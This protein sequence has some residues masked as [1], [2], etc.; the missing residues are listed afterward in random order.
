[1]LGVP[2]RRVILNILA[3]GVLIV[4]TG[5]VFGVLLAVVSQDGFN[6]FFQWRYDTPLVFVR[7]TPPVIWRAVRA[8][9]GVAAVGALLFDMLLLSRGLV[10]SLADRLD[11]VG[12][13]VRVTTG[14]ALSIA[15]DRI[16]LA[17]D[18][19][20]TVSRLPEVEAVA[21]KR[22]SAGWVLWSGFRVPLT[23]VGASPG[24]HAGWQVVKGKDLHE[25]TGALPPVV[26]SRSVLSATV[27]PDRRVTT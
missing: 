27:A 5:V 13:D 12:F 24:Q 17:S 10:V 20:K 14:E 1:M 7:I 18:V 2:R 11:R 26:V 15:G 21:S 4:L 16:Q 9:L 25:A 3:E 23:I 6:R 19:F 8:I 22:I